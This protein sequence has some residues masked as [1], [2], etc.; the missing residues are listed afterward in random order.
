ML[1]LLGPSFEGSN[2]EY[3][4][5]ARATGLV[6]YDLRTKLKPK[7]WG[8]VRALGDSVKA[9]EL[10]EQLRADGFR[11]AV[12]DPV[13][14]HDAER[15]FVPLDGISLDEDNMLLRLRGREMPIPWGACLCAVR[16][17]VQLGRRPTGPQSRSSSSTFRAVVPSS[18]EV[19]VFRESMTSL[20]DFDAYAAAD[21]HF[22]TVKWIARIDARHFDFSVL[23]D[24]SGNPA[25][26]LD[27]LIDIIAERSGGMRV[28]RSI[29]A[30]SVA[31]FTG[32]PTGMR[33]M[34]P[35]SS[36]RVPTASSRPPAPSDSHFDAYS[37]II[38]EAERLT[39]QRSSS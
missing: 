29:R 34:T 24:P 28:D 7:T 4:K 36:P 11:I 30:S 5:L 25:E 38:A 33:S 2:E 18:S 17:E 1:V 20:S 16:G 6:A 15:K 22:V 13:V 14:G 12:I 10:A 27:R 35:A 26:D 37:R 23:G 21:L 39:R 32:R 19:Q 8:V 9:Q 31:S 3:A